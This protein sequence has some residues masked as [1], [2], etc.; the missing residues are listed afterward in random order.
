MLYVCGTR[1][2]RV[3]I[4]SKPHALHGYDYNACGL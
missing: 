4:G 2:V 1:V 3:L